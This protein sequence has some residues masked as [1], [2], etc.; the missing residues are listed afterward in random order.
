[1]ESQELEPGFS[2]TADSA[3]NSRKAN[4]NVNSNHVDSMGPGDFLTPE[5]SIWSSDKDYLAHFSSELLTSSSTTL[6]GQNFKLSTNMAK[7]DVGMLEMENCQDVMQGKKEV[8]VPP[9]EWIIKLIF[10]LRFCKSRRALYL[11][12]QSLND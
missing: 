3:T 4:S 9:G 1:M 2:S 7:N 11:M 8:S 12:P 10:T 6:L 5:S